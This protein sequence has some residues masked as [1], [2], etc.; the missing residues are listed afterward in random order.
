MSLLI[1]I[2]SMSFPTPLDDDNPTTQGGLQRTI[3]TIIKAKDNTNNN[4]GLEA[5]TD[6]VESINGSDYDEEDGYFL[7]QENN[8]LSIIFTKD[9][10]ERMKRSGVEEYNSTT[11]DRF[12]QRM[13]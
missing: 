6:E 1:I 10:M 12:D 2:F 11:Y 4:Q 8:T 13:K 9:D 7:D 3:P 5:G